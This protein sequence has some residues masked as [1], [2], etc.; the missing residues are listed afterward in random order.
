MNDTIL[1][2]ITN[3]I[4]VLTFNRPEA[5]N[6]LNAEMAAELSAKTEQILF[7]NTIRAVLLRGA[8][9]LFMAGGDIRFFQQTM[10][11]MP[12]GVLNLV[13]LVNGIIAN[14]LQSPK[15]VLA[16]VHGSVAGIGMSFMMAADL[17]I[18]GANTQFTMAYSKLGISP[19]GG[20]TYF[21][22][23]IVGHKKAMELALL[24]EVIT[25]NQAQD[26]GLINW[27][28]PEDQLEE[29]ALQLLNKLANGPTQAYAHTKQLMQQSANNSL[30]QQLDAEAFA[31]AHLSQTTDFRSGVTG[32]LNKTKPEFVGK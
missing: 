9:N 19:D 25:A 11:T 21:L 15:P 7:D 17:V 12:K 13:R 32:F 26:L 28:V 8:G 16:C 18:A 30:A 31:F 3:N 2:S 6:S 20:A 10:D 4:A 29:K 5:M 14:L 24:S 23:K 1:L 27:L 22:P